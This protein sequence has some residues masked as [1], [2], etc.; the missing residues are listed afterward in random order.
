MYDAIVVG[1]RVA[2]ATSAMLLARAGHRVLL[3]DRATFPSDTM[4]THYVHQPAIARLAR[5]G[6]L[7]RLAATGC[8]PLEV[9]RWTLEDVSITGCAPPVDGIRAAYGPRR[10]VLD[11]L[12]VTAAVEAGAELR[13]RANVTGLVRDGDRV[14]GVRVKGADGREITERA[15]VVIGADGIDSLVAREAGARRYEEA[16]TLNCLYYTYWNGLKADYEVYVRGRRAIGV[17]PTHDDNV[18]IGIQWPR[19]LF[20]SVRGD[21]EGSYLKVLEDTAPELAERVRASERAARFTGTGRLPNFFRQASGPGW[22]LVGD[23]GFHKDPVGAFGISDALR[24][25]DLLAGL[26]A[27]ALGGE[28]PVDEALRDF[29]EQRD[30]DAMP[31]YFFNLQAAQLEP[32][33]ELLNVLRVIGDDQDETDRFFGLIAGSYTWDVFFTPDLIE[34]AAAL[35]AQEA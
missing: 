17:V 31:E 14:A 6:L 30:E 7:D 23:S 33:P 11:H 34:R 10:Y 24:H 12:L 21:I 13:E 26:L 19:A 3:L 35:A 18:M 29:A 15:T 32:M 9:A 27:P 20:D 5:W 28:R 4:S 22:A 25:A 16:P 8:P 2:G 1:A